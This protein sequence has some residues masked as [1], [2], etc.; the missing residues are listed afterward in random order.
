MKLLPKK[1]IS[2]WVFNN[3]ERFANY[4][5]FNWYF[6][7]QLQVFNFFNKQDK[8]LGKNQ[9]GKQEEI[10]FD[11]W[12]QS[13]FTDYFLKSLNAGNSLGQASL[14]TLK[15]LDK[16]LVVLGERHILNKNK[17][18]T[19]YRIQG[20]LGE[21]LKEKKISKSLET[22]ITSDFKKLKLMTST[23]KEMKNFSQRIGNALEII[24]KFSPSSWDSFVAFTE[25]IIPIK[26]AEFVSYSH[27]DLP[28]YSMI[29]LY[30]RDFIDLI[31]DLLHENGHHHLN[32]YLNLNKLIEEPADTI[33]YSPWRRTLRPLRGI[34]HAYF[35][36]FWAFKLFS[37]L[38]SV[39]N[40]DSEV[41]HFT[42]KEKEKCLWRAIEEYYM[43][44]FTFKDL[45]IARKKGL[46][47]DVGWP[48]IEE[49]QREI[50]KFKRK[51]N[52]LEKKLSFYKKDLIAL[53][54]TL[55]QAEKDYKVIN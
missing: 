39:R 28:G 46:I 7:N 36:F 38:A 2:T 47:H 24:Q 44:N 29:N 16:H 52:H 40:L 1:S 5:D 15:I 8:N 37:D 34:Y 32:H 51:V 31:D 50:F 42:D 14:R 53:K 19:H 49:Q 41:Y 26:E 3:S 54:A 6:L 22:I 11:K 45:K 18:S 10:V 9:F 21:F 43:L 55:S 13:E 4:S 48:L 12:N 35:T 17:L 30:H 20:S 25:V 33:Y 27:Q 23:L